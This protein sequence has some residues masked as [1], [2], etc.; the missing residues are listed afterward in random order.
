M[1]V[2]LVQLKCPSCGADLEIQ[3]GRDYTFCQFCG[4][5]VQIQNDHEY[6]YRHIDEAGL[7]RAETERMVKMKELE[8][9]EEKRKNK[10]KTIK[11]WL[12]TT[13][14]FL[15]LGFLGLVMEMAF[16][17]FLGFPLMFCLSIGMFVGMLGIPLFFSDF[18]NKPR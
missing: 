12:I 5:K 15:G 14:V 11:I 9:E 4:T 18:W 6:V 16:D 13:I 10:K 17:S 7:K 2:S 8:F 1:S 3:E